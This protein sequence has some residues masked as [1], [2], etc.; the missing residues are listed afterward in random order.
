MSPDAFA[1]LSRMQS[2]LV[3]TVRLVG[4]ITACVIYFIVVFD[5]ALF[6]LSVLPCFCCYLRLVVLIVPFWCRDYRKRDVIGW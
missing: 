6:Y 3:I 2:I 1:V 4:V 5:S